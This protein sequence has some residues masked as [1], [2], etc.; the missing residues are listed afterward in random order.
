MVY[1]TWLNTIVYYDVLQPYSIF[2]VLFLSR[3]L[4]PILFF[5]IQHVSKPNEFDISQAFVN[6]SATLFSELIFTTLI[7]P[8][9]KF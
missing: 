8:F 7:F 3:N 5:Y 6:K 2:I 4:I 9:L 1:N